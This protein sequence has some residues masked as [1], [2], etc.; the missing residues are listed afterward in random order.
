LFAGLGEKG[1]APDSGACIGV[2]ERKGEYQR[3]R[4]QSAVQNEFQSI[5]MAVV[6]VFIE[7][8][9]PRVRT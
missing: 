3:K 6:A 2:P 5:V 8:R 1:L 4:A 9:R 7:R